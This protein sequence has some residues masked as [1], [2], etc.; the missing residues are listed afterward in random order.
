MNILRATLFFM[1]K[2]QKYSL[3]Y[4][5]NSYHFALTNAA[6][7]KVWNWNIHT[8]DSTTLLHRVQ[9]FLGSW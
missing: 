4:V 8:H 2:G 6:P 3:F 1:F 5:I 7:E 9:S